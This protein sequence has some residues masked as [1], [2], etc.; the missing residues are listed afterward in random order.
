MDWLTG[1]AWI[2]DPDTVLGVVT[3]VGAG[4]AEE[5]TWDTANWAAW[6]ICSEM[7]VLMRALVSLMSTLRASTAWPVVSR[8]RLDSLVV[9]VLIIEQVK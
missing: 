7:K 2:T 9:G 4:T 3:S 8:D 1:T 6:G 5:A